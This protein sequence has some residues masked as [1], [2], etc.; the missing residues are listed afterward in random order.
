MSFFH[1]EEDGS[2]E[3]VP[4]LP[5]QLPEGELVL[6]QGRPSSLT[7]AIHAFHIRFVALYFA[8]IAVWRGVTM[9]AAGAGFA[10]LVTAFF[11]SALS[12]AIA[13]GIL[14]G[15][16]HVMARATIYTITNK[17]I[18]LRYG[19]AIRKYAN[20]PFSSLSA[21]S[22][23]RH[24]SNAGSI[25]LQTAKDAHI[26]YLKIWPHAR[27]MRFSKPEPM[28][29]AIGDVD[30]V[31]RTLCHAMKSNAPGDVVIGESNPVKATERESAPIGAAPAT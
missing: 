29:R 22:M 5:A 14:T 18:F 30:D 8:A 16:A 19:A 23:R 3:P 13:V 24:G 15:I 9:I 2:P 6:W 31:V 12:A 17:R 25:A 4:G 27:P 11:V 20:I 7:L 21:V 10:D 26:G 28:L 1:D